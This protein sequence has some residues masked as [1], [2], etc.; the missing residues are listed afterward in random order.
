MCVINSKKNRLN[1]LIIANLEHASPRIPGLAQYLCSENNLVR[2]ITPLSGSNYK[3]RWAINSLDKNNF[4][5]IE[6]PYN[7]DILQIVR[8][9]LWFIGFNKGISLTEQLKVISN[10]NKTEV[11]SKQSYFSKLRKNLPEWLLLGYQ[12]IFGIPD[13]EIT[14]FRSAYNKASNEIKINPPDIII[15]S[16]PYT[17]SHLVA[18]KLVKI[19]KIPWLADFRDTWSNNP[20]Y[21]YSSLR[22]KFD[23]YLEKR[24]LS[25]A[26]MIMTVSQTYS[27]KLNDIHN[28]EIHVIANGYTQLNNKINDPLEN[29]KLPLNIVYTGTIY[30]GYQNYREF[31]AAV[32]RAINSGLINRGSLKINFYGR[33]LSGLEHAIFEFDLSE[34]VVQHG[35]VSRE[36]AFRF[37][38][39]ADL[40]LFF[41]WE[42]SEVGGLSHLKLYE[43]LGAM[44]P[45]FISG[46]KSDLANQELVSSTNSGFVGIGAEQISQLL[47]ELLKQK[48]DSGITYA[49]NLEELIK[50]SYFER[51]RSLRNL[52][53]SI[54]FKKE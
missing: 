48:L 49:P 52:I 2:V 4:Q 20:V 16:S 1:I 21:P 26:S 23:T 27:E 7:G 51:G 45:I 25:R 36:D 14:W 46:A 13:L 41:N 29:R 8:K 11:V 40:L 33:F 38:A 28:R 31:L 18:S 34:C 6:A 12:E 17:T 5:V 43:Y 44:K 39:E 32:R 19:H 47:I 42:G 53:T 54:L 30:E 35:V 3:K 37:Q 9:I 22:R 50:H 10:N 24:I 15:S